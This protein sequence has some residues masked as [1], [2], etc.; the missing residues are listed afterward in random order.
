MRAVDQTKRVLALLPASTGYVQGEL[1]VNRSNAY[2]RLR[3]LQ[4]MGLV[5]RAAGAW[6]LTDVGKRNLS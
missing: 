3:V 2:R 4:R 1:G 5:L 6:R